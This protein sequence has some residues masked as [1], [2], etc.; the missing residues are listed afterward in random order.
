MKRR[1]DK[2]EVHHLIRNLDEKRSGELRIQLQNDYK[3]PE[4]GSYS[5]T[6][7]EAYN[8]KIYWERNKKSYNRTDRGTDGRLINFHNNG[9]RC[10]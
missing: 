1:K 2:Y 9:V 5:E 6:L 8:L 10:P 7:A 4:N 3:D